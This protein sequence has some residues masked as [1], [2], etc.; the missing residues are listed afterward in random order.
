ML[1][2]LVEL[3]DFSKEERAC[4]I[5]ISMVLNENFAGCGDTMTLLKQTLDALLHESN[6]CT[7]NRLSIY[8]ILSSSLG[9][10]LFFFLWGWRWDRGPW[11]EG[12]RTK[13][14]GK[15]RGV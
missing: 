13:R 2:L 1:S 8:K 4:G 14:E 12:L 9:S 10:L 6:Y 7:D 5:P 3:N 11:G 15:R